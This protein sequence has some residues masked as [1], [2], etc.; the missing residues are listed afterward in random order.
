MKKKLY[1]AMVVISIMFTGCA[2]KAINT[3]TG[4]LDK[5]VVSEKV[6]YRKISADEA[7]EIIDNGDYNIILDVRLLEEY[8]EGHIKNA[9]I[10]PVDELQ[11]KALEMLTNK[12]DKILVY[13]KSGRR[14]E[15]ASKTLIEMGY[16]NVYD[17]GGLNNWNGQLTTGD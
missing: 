17:F 7:K 13:C 6:E 14:S 2:N 8:K 16:T 3:N 1:I 11:T 5:E 10:I 12:E 4:E 9:I 15:I